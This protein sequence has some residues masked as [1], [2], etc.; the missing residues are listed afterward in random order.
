MAYLLCS[1]WAFG[2][3]PARGCW[4]GTSAAGSPLPPASWF[5]GVALPTRLVSGVDVPVGVGQTACCPGGPA[6]PSTPR[7][8]SHSACWPS[9]WPLG[10]VGVGVTV[11]GV[12]W[13]LRFPDSA[14]VRTVWLCSFVRCSGLLLV[15]LRGW[16][17]FPCGFIGIVCVFLHKSCLVPVEPGGCFSASPDPEGPLTV[18]GFMRDLDGTE[19]CSPLRGV[20]DGREQCHPNTGTWTQRGCRLTAALASR[21][22]CGHGAGLG[23]EACLG[24]CVF[25]GHKPRVNRQLDLKEAGVVLVTLWPRSPGHRSPTCESS[26]PFLGRLSLAA[27]T[28]VCASGWWPCWD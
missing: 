11:A 3:A 5:P 8:S 20:A 19:A 4:E 7:P 13:W 16:L 26:V 24:W 18:R 22:A 1:W 27:D 23:S 17:L 14:R 12:R 28:L 10:W 6:S 25:S 21:P 2:P 9:S 15:F